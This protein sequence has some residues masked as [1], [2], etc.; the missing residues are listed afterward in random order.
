MKDALNIDGKIYISSRRAAEIS[1]YSNDY[2][3]QLCRG[4]KVTARMMGR[5]WFVD[6]ESL[7]SHKKSSEEAFQA[8]CKNA[9]REH[10]EK[11]THS[12]LTIRPLALQAPRLTQDTVMRPTKYPV[13]NWTFAYSSD[14]RSLL[15]QFTKATLPKSE[16]PPI[17][18]NVIGPLSPFAPKKSSLRNVSIRHR[19]A[20]TAL[21]AI[22]VM[23]GGFVLNQ[24][25]FQ[26]SRII[27]Q[28]QTASVISSIDAFFSLIQNTCD[29]TIAFVAEMFSSKY[30]QFARNTEV[31]ILD[32]EPE[33]LDWN[34]MAVVPVS[35]IDG[36]TET[37]RRIRDSFSDVVEIK[38]DQ[39]GTAGVITPVFKKT[40][41]DEFMYVLVP[42]KEE[43][44]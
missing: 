3:G 19:V 35:S 27:S 23:T 15:P 25:G 9:S 38:A 1:K 41:G 31:T 10:K 20:L 39:S 4:G 29:H 44:K 28:S 36:Q 22:I 6:Q 12:D 37:E 40:T 24:N 42:V 8:R 32:P 2:I 21:V 13:L 14:S 43:S 34:G 30:R 17:V 26:S 11:T 16:K 7:L 5:A 33:Q 18:S